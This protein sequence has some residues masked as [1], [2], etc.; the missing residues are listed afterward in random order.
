MTYEEQVQEFAE[1]MRGFFIY[2]DLVFSDYENA[3]RLLKDTLRSLKGKVNRNEAALPMIIA[4]GG[5]YDSEIDR[6]KMREIEALLR[7]IE[8]R[9]ELKTSIRQKKKSEKK[10]SN[11]KSRSISK[12]CFYYQKQTTITHVI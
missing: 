11:Y 9:K 12:T 7:L 6:A 3:E 1:M 2:F 4:M 5:S 10:C 8:S